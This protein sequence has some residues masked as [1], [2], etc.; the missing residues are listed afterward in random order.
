MF[1]CTR[2]K[3][4]TGTFLDTYQGF[5]VHRSSVKGLR[6]LGVQTQ[7]A[8]LPC[9]PAALHFLCLHHVGQRRGGPFVLERIWGMCIISCEVRVDGGEPQL[10]D[11]C[12]VRG[13]V[14]F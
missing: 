14:F 2:C 12:E 6:S 3:S 9:L 13:A 10:R 4:S 1:S 7:V 5:C 11:G 8:S